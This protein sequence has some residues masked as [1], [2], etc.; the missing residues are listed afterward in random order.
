MVS[1]FS[2]SRARVGGRRLFVC[3]ALTVL[4][5]CAWSAVVRPPAARAATGV[6]EGW[7][8]DPGGNGVFVSVYF[9]RYD[10]ATWVD[11]G[12]TMSRYAADGVLHM[13]LEPGQYRIYFSGDWAL[14]GEWYNDVKNPDA[15]ASVLVTSGNT[16]TLATVTLAPAGHVSGRVTDAQGHPLEDISI[17][18][19]YPDGRRV[20]SDQGWG[21]TTT[22]GSGNY[23]I[24]GLEPGTYYLEF[25]D[26][27][28][29]Y[30]TEFHHDRI[31][32]DAAD[33]FAVDG[34]LTTTGIDAVLPR[35]GVIS[36]TVRNKQGQPL[37]DVSVI[38][39]CPNGTGGWY[40]VAWDS[41]GSDGKYKLD[42]LPSG[43]HGYRLCFSDGTGA[44]A[45]QYY[46]NKP[47]A[48]AGDKVTVGADATTTINAVLARGGP[49]PVALAKV[50]VKKGKTATFRFRVNDAGAAK[51]TV[52]IKIFKGTKLKGTLKV[53]SRAT[54]VALS[55][56]W[57]CT[58]AK[59]TYVWKIYARD[60]AGRSQTKVA[61]QK[62]TVK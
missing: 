20:M 42:R 34:G 51:A 31:A 47:S 19:H 55:Y 57:K 29:Q 8:Q 9:F 17:I 18:L 15:A 41:T 22:S 37:D 36:G 44:Y 27:N 25:W 16:F 32:E 4:V 6:I 11:A 1:R 61:S 14:L 43:D 54:N 12:S 26:W 48:A 39:K 40:W 23:V 13:E 35:A 38:L 45:T 30:A 7:V 59:G 21:D 10:G 49:T 62:L 33:T 2:V 53:G 50:S 58:L 46:N 24:D 28:G 60:S 52:T 5:V 56:R 3:L